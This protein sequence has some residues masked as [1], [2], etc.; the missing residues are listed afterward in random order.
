VTLRATV[1]CGLLL[2]AGC[3]DGSAPTTSP[4]DLRA[5]AVQSAREVARDLAALRFAVDG[6]GRYAQ[7]RDDGALVLYEVSVRLRPTPATAPAPRLPAVTAALTRGGWAVDPGRGSTGASG[8]D[9]VLTRTGSALRAR[10]Y[11]ADPTLLLLTLTSPCTAA[12]DETYPARPGEL[13]T[14][15]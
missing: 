5:G 10:E 12:P 13:L 11:A 15:P 6:S 7:C 9:V 8:T 1:L 2:L 4:E 14:L 3:T